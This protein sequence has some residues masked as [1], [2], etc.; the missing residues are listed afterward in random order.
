MVR[1]AIKADIAMSAFVV[2]Y[3]LLLPDMVLPALSGRI[4]RS[5]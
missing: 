5:A 3:G 2:R 1:I 4:V